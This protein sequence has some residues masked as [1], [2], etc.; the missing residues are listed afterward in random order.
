MWKIPFGARSAN[1]PQ[2]HY[3]LLFPAQAMLLFITI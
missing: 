3:L 1:L 2:K